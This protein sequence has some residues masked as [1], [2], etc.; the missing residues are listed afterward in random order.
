MVWN[1]YMKLGKKYEFSKV[2]FW[3]NLFIYNRIDLDNTHISNLFF[4]PRI[5]LIPLDMKRNANPL[6]E[7]AFLLSVSVSI[8]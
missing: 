1:R 8:L 6:Y 5:T 7:S 4:I 2:N 3:I